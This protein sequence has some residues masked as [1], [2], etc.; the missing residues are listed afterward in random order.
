MANRRQILTYGGLWRKR[1]KVNSEFESSPR[2]GRSTL[3]LLCSKQSKYRSQQSSETAF[4]AVAAEHTGVTCSG[5]Y[6]NFL[7]HAVMYQ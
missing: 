3:K 2:I 1:A 6:Q 4:D 5:R 7:H